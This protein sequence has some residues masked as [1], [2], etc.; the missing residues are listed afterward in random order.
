MFCSVHAQRIVAHLLKT[1]VIF[2]QMSSVCVCVCM[3]THTHTHTHTYI[4]INN[5]CS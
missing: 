5:T 2:V 3:R 1:Y 4:Y